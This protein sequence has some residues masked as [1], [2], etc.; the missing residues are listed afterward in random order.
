MDIAT[1]IGKGESTPPRSLSTVLNTLWMEEESSGCP[2]F[3]LSF[4]FFNYN[5]HNYLVHSSVIANI[6]PLSIARKMNSQW[7]ETSMRI[8]Q[9]DRKLVPDIGELRDVIIQLSH[10]SRVHQCINIVVVDIHEAYGLLLSS[11]WSRLLDG[12]F[13]RLV[14]H[15]ASL[16][17]KMQPVLG[18]VQELYEAKCYPP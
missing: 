8:I 18:F 15:V 1:S 16:Q 5:V 6:M 4:E 17:G 12:Y 10:D 3:L 9:L 14:L 7:S 2:P 13:A 11:D